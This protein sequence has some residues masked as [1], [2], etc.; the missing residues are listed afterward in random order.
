MISNGISKFQFEL[1][2]RKSHN[3][4]IS[5]FHENLSKVKRFFKGSENVA[6]FGDLK[7]GWDDSSIH[8]ANLATV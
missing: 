4:I 3:L 5:L 1:E 6:K 2:N 7:L 8:F